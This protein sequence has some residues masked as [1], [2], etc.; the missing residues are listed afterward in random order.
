[1]E[2]INAGFFVAFVIIGVVAA[3]G[4]LLLCLANRIGSSR[5]LHEELQANQ[6]E[7]D[8]PVS[9][10]RQIRV[11]E[12]LTIGKKVSKWRDG[13]QVLFLDPMRNGRGYTKCDR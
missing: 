5:Y 11:L 3:V 10:D 8:P 6:S 13:E 9:P 4:L 12:K 7:Q 2:P 1:M